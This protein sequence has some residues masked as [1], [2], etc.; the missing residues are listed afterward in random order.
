MKKLFLF[1]A[2]A[3]FLFSLSS[4]GGGKGES[5]SS[6]F[7]LSEYVA[8]MQN[9]SEV[10]KELEAKLD[11]VKDLGELAKLMQQSKD[12]MTKYKDAVKALAEQDMGKEVTV[13]IADGAPF[14]LET[15][16]K[17]GKTLPYSDAI[18]IKLEGEVA[19]KE[20]VTLT[21][22]N[23]YLN[24]NLNVLDKEGNIIYT[25]K[26]LASFVGTKN[27]EGAVV[28]AADSKAKVGEYILIKEDAIE[29]WANAA[30]LELA[31]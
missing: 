20:P 5:S 1:V 12:E 23:K 26:N 8:I 6:K 2:A 11:N 27:E 19:L 18:W 9:A 29:D 14:V 25:K 7:T 22:G 24:V 4:C 15:P 13:E 30:K 3:A 16:L 10:S 31:L 17:F 21:D 28:V